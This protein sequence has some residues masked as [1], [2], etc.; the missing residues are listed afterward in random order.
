MAIKTNKTSL[1]YIKWRERLRLKAC[2]D[3]SLPSGHAAAAGALSR[4]QYA[5]HRK[6]ETH[7][8]LV[9]GLRQYEQA[10]DFMV[11]VN[12]DNNRFAMLISFT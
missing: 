11:T 4:R 10:A 9:G 7:A 2:Q 1:G 6:S 5:D 3:H 8:V 12:T